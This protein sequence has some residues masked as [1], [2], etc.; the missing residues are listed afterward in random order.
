MAQRA[1]LARALARSPGV[2]LLDE[3]FGALDAL[4]KGSLHDELLRMWRENFFANIGDVFIGVNDILQG[5]FQEG[6]EDWMRVVFN[7]TIGLGGIHDVAS[8]MGIEKRNEY[9]TN[10]YH[11]VSD[12][13]KPD[14]DMTGIVDDTRLLFRVGLEVANGSDWPRWHPGTEFRDRRLVTSIAIFGQESSSSQSSTDAPITF[15]LRFS[16]RA[17]CTAAST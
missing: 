2:L 9:T 14:W 8:D 4:S 6:F 17:F 7:T 5:K 3:P 1:S 12:E 13:V 10:D 15:S 11:K 16:S